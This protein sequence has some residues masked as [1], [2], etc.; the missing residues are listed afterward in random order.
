VLAALAPEQR[1]IAEQVL[2]GGLAGVRHAVEEQNTQAKAAGGPEIKA[3][4]ILTLAEELLPG[5]R[6]AEWRDRGEAAAAAI[7]DISLRDLRTVVAGADAA[8]R[9]EESRALAARLREGLERRA[10]AEREAWTDEIKTCL[11]EGRVVRALRVSGRAP[12]QGLRLPPEI[13]SGLSTAAGEAMTA[14]TAVD[15]WMALLEAVLSSPIR[16]TIQPKA[17]PAGVDD[18]TR[19]TLRQSIAKVPALGPLLGESPSSRPLP[20][21]PPRRPPAPPT[22]SAT[23][24]AADAAPTAANR[25]TVEDS[26]PSDAP[27]SEATLGASAEPAGS[28]APPAAGPVPAMAGGGPE[29]APEGPGP[30]AAEPTEP[31]EP[32]E[33]AGE[34]TEPAG[35]PTEPAGEPTEPAGEPTEPTEPAGE[36]TAAV[37]GGPGAS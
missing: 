9:D 22:S 35:E 32:T 11:A 6:A 24:E 34:P 29:L 7:D 31:I 27:P 19:K 36:P 21:P 1:A 16:R 12:E 20:P 18:E 15:R 25:A 10:A 33:P 3:D 26:G 17:L 8:G 13:A 14:D 28:D 5:L 2:R 30:V 23:P 4:A 37:P